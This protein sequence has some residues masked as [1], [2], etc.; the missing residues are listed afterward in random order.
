[1]TTMKHEKEDQIFQKVR[2]AVMLQIYIWFEFWGFCSG[3]VEDTILL[4]QN[5]ASLVTRYRRFEVTYCFVLSS[6][7][8]RE[9][10]YSK[11]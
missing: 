5:A 8:V 2:V 1:M 11:E 4:G 6:L 10:F 7:D 9:N 3:V